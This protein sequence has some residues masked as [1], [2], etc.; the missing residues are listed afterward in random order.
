LPE[1]NPGKADKIVLSEGQGRTRISLEASAIGRDL[2]ICIY[3]DSP[4]I[5]AVAVGEY[6][7]EHQR[8]SVSVMT[9]LG[10]KDDA[11]AQ[12]CAHDISRSTHKPVC[13]IAGVHLDDIKLDEI[14]L[15]QSNTHLLVERF[16]SQYP[17]S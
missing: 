15:I 7:F 11:L 2:I 1:N 17:L 13:V 9:R 12:S 14:K 4:H 16:L 3:N 5:G 6:D 8:A 10:H